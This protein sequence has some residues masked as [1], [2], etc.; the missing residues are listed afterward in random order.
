[1]TTTGQTVLAAGGWAVVAFL[2]ILLL[3]ALVGLA[4]FLLKRTGQVEKP[5][6]E[7]VADLQAQGV[8][9]PERELNDRIDHEQ[10]D[11]VTPDAVD[12]EPVG[13]GRGE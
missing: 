7:R 11:E 10:Q 4:I 12:S 13:P 8:R 9:N 1:M 5:S 2:V 6:A 3:A